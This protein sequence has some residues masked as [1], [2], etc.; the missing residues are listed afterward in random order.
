M[1]VR[2][3]L[4]VVIIAV[5]IAISSG[6]GIFVAYMQTPQFAWHEYKVNAEL[7]AG[8]D[9][10]FAIQSASG[11]DMA[12]RQDLFVQSDMPISFIRLSEEERTKCY[13][14]NITSQIVECPPVASAI[15]RLRDHRDPKA[16]IAGAALR[17][18]LGDAMTGKLF[19]P[20]HVTVTNRLLVCTA[21][22]AHAKEW[23]A[24]QQR[25]N[26]K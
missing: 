4:P 2:I 12:I 1:S 21:H 25:K 17:L 15:L 19:N 26:E 6:V 9:I 11:S 20:N 10:Q 3:T 23:V 24:E 22:C 18:Y 13:A 16:A 8:D 14:M 5:L 7:N